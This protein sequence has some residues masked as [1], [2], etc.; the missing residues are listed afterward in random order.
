[1]RRKGVLRGRG[2]GGRVASAS[3]DGCGSREIH[4]GRSI[5]VLIRPLTIMNYRSISGAGGRMVSVLRR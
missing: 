5:H 4:G 3:R 2:N 1:M